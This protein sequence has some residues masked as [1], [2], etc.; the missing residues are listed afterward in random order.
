M[1]MAVDDRVRAISLAMGLNPIIWTATPGGAKF[2][3]NG[4]SRPRFGMVTDLIDNAFQI[5]EWLMVKSPGRNPSRLS[6]V[7]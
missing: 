7:F 5:G 4:K 2:D 3:T 1:L 6:K